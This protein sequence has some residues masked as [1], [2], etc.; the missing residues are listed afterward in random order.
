M[1]IGIKENK[2]DNHLSHEEYVTFLYRNILKREP[3][4]EGLLTHTAALRKHGDHTKIFKEFLDSSEFSNQ[5]L[6]N[7]Q[8]LEPTLRAKT[9]HGAGSI[10]TATLIESSLDHFYNIDFIESLLFRL[11]IE[12]KSSSHLK[13]I[14]VYYPKMSNGGTERVTSRQILSWIKLGYKVILLTDLPE[15]KE[16]DYPYGDVERIII[17]GKM[18]HNHD[19]RA[20]GRALAAILTSYK[21]DVFV[22]N[23]WDETSTVWDVLVAKS[24]GIPVVVGWH[25]VFDTRIRQPDDLHLANIRLAG[26]RYANLVTTLSTVDQLWF[27][28]RGITARVVY[29]PL[30]FDALPKKVAP[31]DGKTVIWVARAERHQKRL[32]LAIRMFPL[33]LEQVPEATLLIVGDGPDLKWAKEYAR[34][35]GISSRVNFAGYTTDVAQHLAQSDVHILTSEFEGWCLALGEAWAYGLPS[36]MFELPYLEYVQNGKGFIAVPMG[37]ISSM[38][39]AVARLL[40]DNDLRKRVGQESRQVAEEFDRVSVQEEWRQIFSGIEAGENLSPTLTPEHELRGFKALT[41]VLADRFLSLNKENTDGFRPVLPS[42]K[43]AWR[44]RKRLTR[45]ILKTGKVIAAPLLKTKQAV[46]LIVTGRDRRLKMIDLSHVGLGDNIMIWTG[47][48]TL[49]S[50]DVP[51]CAPGCVM[52]VQPILADLASRLFAPYGIVIQR[53]RPQQEISPIYTPL[54]PVGFKQWWRAYIGRD[55][56]MNWVEALDEQKTFPRNGSDTSL[57]ARVRLAISERFLYRR[58]NW[59]EATPSYIGYRVWLPVALAHGVY[60]LPF[61]SQMKRSLSTMRKIVSDYIDGFTPISDREHYEGSAAFPTGKSFQTIAPEAF[62]KINSLLGNNFFECYVQKDSP[63]FPV[64]ENSG[65]NPHSLDDIK[66]TFRIIKYSKNLLTTDSF[67]SHVA[68]LLRDDFTLVLSRDMKESICHPGADP[69]IVANHPACAPCNYQ[70]RQDFE[71]CVAGYEHC[72]AFE[73]EAFVSRI[74]A[75]F[76]HKKHAENARTDL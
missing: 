48:F 25:N 54:P 1:M 72:I 31:L 70:E 42:D 62:S 7:N 16:N 50:N 58:R 63:W 35:L 4:D 34:S 61:L 30:T 23:L 76:N 13:V 69:M 28:D 64:Y 27:R 21:V 32:D 60:P 53:G 20:R 45:H 3:D 44:P 19:Y 14:A 22:N 37:D 52:H 38:A 51:L 68:Q 46:D 56:R 49:L 2:G 75:C 6:Y 57:S 29:N 67:T 55:W 40:L 47:L 5:S 8:S 71:R 10:D 73:N 9:N 43:P 12:R 66:D 24:L 15:D 59:A 74:A 41:T 26:Y 17:P 39:D 18:M 33:V 36:V 65:L 11:N